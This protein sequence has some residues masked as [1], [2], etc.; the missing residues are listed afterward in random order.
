[1]HEISTMHWITVIW[2]AAGGACLM[3]AL[4]HL[5]VWWRERRGWAH[6]SFF[7]MVAGVL[8]MAVCELLIMRT[9]S[10]GTASAAVRWAHGFTLLITVGCLGF[11]HFHFGTGRR[12]LLLLALGLRL[13]AVVANF[14]TGSSLHYRAL[15]Q[16]GKMN[17]MGEKVSVPAVWDP[18]PWL[19][20]GQAAAFVLL[21]VVVDASLKL[22]R[23]GSPD[24]RRRAVLLG[25][26]MTVFLL[27]APVIAGLNAAGLVK[28]PLLASFPFLGMVLAMGYELSRGVLRAARLTTDLQQTETRL[29]QAATAARL[30][31]WEW[32]LLTDSIWIPLE[33]RQLYGVG[34]DEVIDIQRFAATVHPEDRA[35]V[36]AA[37]AATLA[38]TA[39]YAADYRIILPDG[40][41]RWIGAHGRVERDASGK[42][43]LLRGVSIDITE[44]RLAED[45][46]RIVFEASP[47]ALIV[48]DGEGIIVLANAQ[49]EAVF[50]YSRP[51]LTGHSIERLVPG[52]YHGH[53][54]GHRR[55]YFTDPEPGARAMGSGRD[56]FG[57]HKAGHEVPVEIGL[58]PFRTSDG[59]FVLASIAD[60]TDRK[61]A[62]QETLRHHVELAHLGRVASLSELSGSL[63]H[64]LNQPLAAILSNAQA[65]LRFM[66]HDPPAAAE[67]REILTDIVG[68]GRRAGDV[69]RRMRRML[70]KGELAMELLDPASLTEE[71]LSLMKS[72]LVAKNVRVTTHYPGD[73][74]RV[75]GDRIQLQ[76]VLLNL[77][78]NACEAMAGSS[79]DR[80]TI[81]VD[82]SGADGRMS[83]CVKDQGHGL[84]PGTEE[85]I[86]DPFHTTK[87]DGLGMGLAICR[88]ILTA[89]GGKLSAE[90]HPEGGAVFR[91]E[92]PLHEAEPP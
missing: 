78:A 22:W 51:E 84:T 35:G 17:F 59:L 85:K 11:V 60:I 62:E 13:I 44:R 37:I 61:H 30:G 24:G 86:F 71:V 72:D 91:V 66:E 74:L 2:S 4:M 1:M 55:G 28:M 67:V 6:L 31:L 49:V 40:R 23:G 88:S 92:L 52:R 33:G 79:R 21:I 83:L 90:N 77:L 38:G 63:A 29:S 8:G 12:W 76:Q 80:R 81:I 41:I 34:P 45:R 15:H 46:F 32:N 64:E 14:T 87:A 68:Q 70:K 19:R 7:V 89:H 20:L 50:G 16:L 82:L 57:R 5:V 75:Y 56:L 3:L 73:P 26:S 42:A 9:D 47:N 25:G 43:I 58:S 53:H 27:M 39:P 48:V 69:I 54:P 18:N 36:N 10:V 65:A